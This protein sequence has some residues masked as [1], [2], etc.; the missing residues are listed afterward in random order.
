MA[1][2]VVAFGAWKSW[3]WTMVL[4]AGLAMP[5]FVPMNLAYFVALV[6]FLADRIGADRVLLGV[7]SER[8]DR[9]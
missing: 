5:N 7:R 8:V 6:P 9:P 1:V 2:A 4:A 3:R